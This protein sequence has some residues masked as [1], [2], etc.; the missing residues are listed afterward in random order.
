MTR[1]WRWIIVENVLGFNWP[2]FYYDNFK[3]YVTIGA[4]FDTS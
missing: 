1:A 4:D 2:G 3:A